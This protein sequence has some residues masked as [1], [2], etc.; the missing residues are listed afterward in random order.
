MKKFMIDKID[1]SPIYKHPSNANKI[2]GKTTLLN[3]TTCIHCMKCINLCPMHVFE[4]KEYDNS[5]IIL[6]TGESN[7]I[8]CQTCSRNCPTNSIFINESFINGIRIAI[9]EAGSDKLQQAYRYY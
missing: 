6:P 5:R 1:Y 4:I 9:R 8:Q 2:A 7:C 3:I